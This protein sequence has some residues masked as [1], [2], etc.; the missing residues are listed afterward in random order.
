[1]RPQNL[2]SVFLY[3]GLTLSIISCKTL[4]S[5][6]FSIKGLDTTIKATKISISDLA[7]N[8]KLYQGQCIET[9]GRFCQAF[10]EFAIYTDNSIFTSDAEGF[11]LGTNRQLNIDNASFDKMNGKRVTIKGRID[12]TKKGHLASYLATIDSIYFWQ[13]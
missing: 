2:A 1:M 5:T 11:W 3:L 8:Y 9:T 7:K 10:E 12:T 4:P 6:T 13:H